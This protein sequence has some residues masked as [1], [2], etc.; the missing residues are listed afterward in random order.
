MQTLIKVS[1]S[2]RVDFTA[3]KIN[4]KRETLHNDKGS[5]VQIDMS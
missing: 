2:I 4:K 5:V 1:V 3:E